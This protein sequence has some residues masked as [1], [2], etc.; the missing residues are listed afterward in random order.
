M[1]GNAATN[2]YPTAAH[3]QPH[4]APDSGPNKIQALSADAIKLVV[5][6]KK[7][8]FLFAVR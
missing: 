2:A 7:P 4:V 1:I 6:E 3:T 5:S 8:I